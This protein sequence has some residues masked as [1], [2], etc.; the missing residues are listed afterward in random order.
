[1]RVF[2]G[3]HNFDIMHPY[4]MVPYLHTYVPVSSLSSLS[5][6]LDSTPI[7]PGPPARNRHLFLASGPYMCTPNFVK[8]GE[9]KEEKKKKKRRKKKE[10]GGKD[11]AVL[12]VNNR[13][14]STATACNEMI[15][16]EGSK[17]S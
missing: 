14:I 15:A 6:E 10:K 8:R 4:P 12:D 3:V 1:M 13:H 7:V 2:P 5:L 17:S 9:E 11:D 16:R